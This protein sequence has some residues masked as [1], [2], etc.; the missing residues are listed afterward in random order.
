MMMMQQKPITH[1]A[2]EQTN[3]QSIHPSLDYIFTISQV[4]YQ[5]PILTVNS[6]LPSPPLLHS[7]RYPKEPAASNYR[8]I[9]ICEIPAHDLRILATAY[10]PPCIEL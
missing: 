4:P 3:N 10:D 9:P 6:I 7:T 2:S 1:S 5:S 8:L